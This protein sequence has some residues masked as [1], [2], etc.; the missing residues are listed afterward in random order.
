MGEGG[1]IPQKPPQLQVE[2]AVLTKAKRR[3]VVT[4]SW[5]RFEGG[6][7]G[8]GCSMGSELQLAKRS[9]GFSCTAR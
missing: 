4:R 3:E 8:E 7:D 5:G 2:F 6:K 1:R 9:S